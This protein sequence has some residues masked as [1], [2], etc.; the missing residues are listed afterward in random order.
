MEYTMAGLRPRGID[1]AL[2]AEKEGREPPDH[3]NSTWREY[4]EKCLREWDAY[5]R[6]DYAEYF[7]KRRKALGLRDI[8]TP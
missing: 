3:K 5:H 1:F 2:Q 4:W 8:T 6:P 7:R